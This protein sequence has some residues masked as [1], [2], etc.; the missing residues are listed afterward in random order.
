MA[1]LLMPSVSLTSAFLP[2]RIVAVRIT[3]SPTR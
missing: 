2:V 3:R 1:V